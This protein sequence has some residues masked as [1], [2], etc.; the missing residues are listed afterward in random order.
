MAQGIRAQGIA[1]KF[2]S[3]IKP[4]IDLLM[5]HDI[6]IIQMRCPELYFDGFVRQ[7]C[8]KDHYD[9][10]HN[11]NICKQVAEKEVE[12]MKMLIDNNHEIVAVLGINFSPSCAVDYVSGRPPHRK[13][14][15]GIYI[16]ELN[17]VMRKEEISNIPFIG[18]SIYRLEETIR[19]LKKVLGG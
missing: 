17:K 14:G 13:R 8:G 18:V 10:H 11:R 5:E 9:N 2:S 1:R 16:E 12:L 15:K 6:N 3:T 4:I 7:P 19:T